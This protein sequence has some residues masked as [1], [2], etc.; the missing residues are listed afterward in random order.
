M[1]GL[2]EIEQE[3]LKTVANIDG[4]PEG[5]YNFRLNGQSIGRKS[6]ENIDVKPKTDKSSYSSHH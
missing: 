2:D 3:V 5:A 4:I 1:L 6:S